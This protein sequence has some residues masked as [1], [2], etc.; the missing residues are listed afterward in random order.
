L[1]SNN[2]PSSQNGGGAPAPQPVLV[3][4]PAAPLLH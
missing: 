4:V 3:P 2:A 1:P